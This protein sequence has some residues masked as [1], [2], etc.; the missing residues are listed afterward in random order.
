MAKAKRVSEQVEHDVRFHRLIVEASG[1]A[2]LIELWASLQVEAR[3][4]IT[5]LRTG[6]DAAE[7]AGRHEQIVDALRRRGMP[8]RRG[9]GSARTSRSSGGCSWRGEL[10]DSHRVD[11]RARRP[12]DASG[13]ATNRNSG[14]PRAAISSRSRLSRM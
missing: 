14:S 8:T 11:H 1:N 2:R 10:R 7:V 6:L 5:A 13:S 4:M 12:A 9:G 3:T